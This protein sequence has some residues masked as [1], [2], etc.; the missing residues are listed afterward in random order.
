MFSKTCQ[1]P[2]IYHQPRHPQQQPREQLHRK[3]ISIISLHSLNNIQLL[4]LL[5]PRKL[6]DP[7]NLH[8][9]LVTF[10]KF[11]YFW[12]IN[13]ISYLCFAVRKPPKTMHWWCKWGGNEGRWGVGTRQ[14]RGRCHQPREGGSQSPGKGPSKTK[15]WKFCF[16]YP[17]CSWNNVP[18]ACRYTDSKILSNFPTFPLKRKEKNY[19]F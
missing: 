4:P 9:R 6:L 3:Q 17:P 16:P 5:H 1:G 11:S 18:L 13:H 7:A 15:A 2:K 19:W 10:L 14:A 12:I 8:T